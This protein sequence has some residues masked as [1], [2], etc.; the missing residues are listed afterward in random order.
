MYRKRLRVAARKIAAN[1]GEQPAGRLK[2]LRKLVVQE[3]RDWSQTGAPRVG[4]KRGELFEVLSAIGYE[5][6]AEEW[7]DVGYY[8]A[9]S[10]LVIWMLYRLV[11][12]AWIIEAS[13]QKFEERAG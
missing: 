4:W 3:K 13:A 8:I 9:Q 5:A 10:F 2:A 1:R 7:G 6:Q 11:T 12:P